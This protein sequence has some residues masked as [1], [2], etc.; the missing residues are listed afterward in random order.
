MMNR[1]FPVK[2]FRALRAVACLATC[3]IGLSV[4]GLAH[5]QTPPPAPLPSNVTVAGRSYI[6]ESIVVVVLFAGAIF[7]VCRTSGRT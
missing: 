6:V 1:S 7:A 5:A 2:K 3:V 4:V